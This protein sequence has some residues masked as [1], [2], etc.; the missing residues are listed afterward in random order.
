MSKAT[1]IY[2]Y[3]YKKRHNISKDAK[4]IHNYLFSKANSVSSYG[5]KDA[6]ILTKFFQEMKDYS[7]MTTN[8]PGEAIKKTLLGQRFDSIPLLDFTKGGRSTGG[9]EFEK[10][11]EKLFNNVVGEEFDKGVGQMTGTSYINLGTTDPEEAVKLISEYVDDEMDKKI[12]NIEKRIISGKDIGA[13]PPDALYL[14]IGG[15]R[16]GKIDVYAGG[17]GLTEEFSFTGGVKPGSNLERAL[18]LL[19]NATFSVKSY[20][21]G[22]SIHLGKTNPKKAVSAVSEYVAAK[23]GKDAA[24]YAGVYFLHHPNGAG[25]NDDPVA[26]AELY[27]HYA[28]M[29]DVYELTGIGL[30]YNDIE[31]LYSVDFLLVNRAG[32]QEIN[33]YSAQDLIKGLGKNGKFN[34]S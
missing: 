24:R 6:D 27:N 11:L 31:E 4:I 10:E 23:T 13:A 8:N 2:R 26:A 7:T 32:G 9:I 25:K 15:K 30:R 28:H 21:T 5:K 20:L 34:I 17:S 14:K 16:Y 1:D 12:K 22:G 19:T 3:Y 29:K 33:V 18:F